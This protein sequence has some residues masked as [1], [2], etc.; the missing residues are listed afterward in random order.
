MD[1]KFF[2]FT[3]PIIG[4]GFSRVVNGQENVTPENIVDQ[5]VKTERLIVTEELDWKSKQIR[6][7]KLISLYEKELVLL[8]EELSKAGNNAIIVDDEAEKLKQS[9]Q[10]SEKARLTAISYLSRIKPRITSLFNNLPTPL[11]QQLED[12]NFILSNDVNNSTLHDSLKAIIKILQ[13]TARFDRSYVF[14]EQPIK[15]NEEMLRANVMYL[16]L[17]CAFLQAGEKYGTAQPSENGWIFQ[18]NAKLKKE[19]K[20]AFAIQ[21]KAVASSFFELPLK[22]NKI[23][24]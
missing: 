21:E 10:H 20:K 22:L 8:N 11:Q 18:E 5:W 23:Q 16:G 15:L 13:E 9:I 24:P 7:S 1:K 4:F 17:S 19:I 3:L 12:Q 2:L 14:E 6:S